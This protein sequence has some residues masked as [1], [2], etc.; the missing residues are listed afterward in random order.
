MNKFIAISSVILAFS[1]SLSA[2]AATPMVESPAKD[3]Q[4]TTF[5]APATKQAPTPPPS[6]YDFGPGMKIP[7]DGSSLEAFNESLAEIKTKTTKAEYTT[8]TNAI[9]Y[10]MV[11]NLEAQMNRAKLAAVLNGE[12]GEEIVN[13]VEWGNNEKTAKSKNS[14]A[15]P[16]DS[17]TADQ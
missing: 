6:R 12:T 11:Y 7:V 16:D 5:M 13:R 15:A 2:S 9:E 14:H 17:P 1:L 10:L 4:E 8:L 3:K